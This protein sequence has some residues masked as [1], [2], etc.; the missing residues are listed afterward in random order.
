MSVRKQAIDPNLVRALTQAATTAGYAPSVHN[1]QPWRWR[2]QPDRLELFAERQRQLGATDPQ[3]RLLMLSCGAALHHARIAL[4]AEGWSAQVEHMPAGGDPDLLAYLIPTGRASAAAETMGLVQAMQVR[5]TDRRPVSDEPVPAASL[6]TIIAAAGD[7][8]GLQP[9]NRDQVIALASAATRA[10]SVEAA[11]RQIA[12]ELAYWTSRAAAEGVGVPEAVLPLQM[13]ETTVPGRDF[14][15]P[16][17][18]PVG[19]GHDR[20][21]HYAVLFGADDEPEGWLRG[22]AAMSAVWLTAAQLGVSVLPLSAVVEV[23]ATRQTLRRILSGLGYPYIVLRLGLADPE[24][25]GPPRTP[26]LPTAQL[27][28]TTPVRSALP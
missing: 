24:H 14:G 7:G 22:G 5:R 8:V 12:G 13:P 3:G 10:G 4:A 1:T 11:D 16:G 9:L 25:A 18:L 17:T 19:P 6:D 23:S 21:A 26:R 2:V 20:A 28:D 27:V 15:R